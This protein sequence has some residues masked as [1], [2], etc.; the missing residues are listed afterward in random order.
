MAS[1]AQAEDERRSR[2]GLRRGRSRDQQSDEPNGDGPQGDVDDL[3]PDIAAQIEAI[4]QAGESAKIDAGAEVEPEVT[5][6][7]EVEAGTEQHAKAKAETEAETEIVP[8]PSRE[9]VPQP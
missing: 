6:S 5:Q 4:A 8:E 9:P 2:F 1:P 7:A 3:P